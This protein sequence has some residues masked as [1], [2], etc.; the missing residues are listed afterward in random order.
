VVAAV[1]RFWRRNGWT[2]ERLTTA[3]EFESRVDFEAVVRLEFAPAQ[4]ERILASDPDRT[5]VD[6]GVLVWWRRF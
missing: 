5:A 3:W 1:E 6:Y 2:P 4:A